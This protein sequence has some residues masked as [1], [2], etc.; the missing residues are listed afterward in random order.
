MKKITLVAINARF[1][2]SSLA[3]LCL[4]HAAFNPKA[5]RLCEYNINNSVSEIAADIISRAP[6][7]A[8]FSCYIWNI[9]HVIK[10]A[11]I[12]KK[13]LPECLILLGGPEV[14]FDCAAFMENCTF[15][16]IIIRGAGELPFAH[17]TK[18]LAQGKDIDT[19]PSAR[20]RTPQ[21]IIETNDAPPYDLSGQPFLYEDLS[22]FENK[23]IYYETSRGCPFCCAYCMSAGDTL[24]FLPLKRVR[25]DLEHFMRANVRQVK[26][27]DRTFNHPDERAREIFAALIALKAKYPDSTTNFHF[28]ISA[29]LLSKQTLSL[30]AA[31]PKHLIQFEVGIQSTNDATLRAVCRAHDT[32]KLLCRTA[33]LCRPQNL[34]VYVDLIA[35]LPMETMQ[36][37]A[38][39]FNDAYSVGSDKIQL[40]FLKLLKGSRMRENATTYGIVYSDHAPYEVLKTHT[41]TYHELRRLHRIEHVLDMLYNQ[42]QARKT[43]DFLI[44]NF[45]SPFVF[46][47]SFTRH[48][49]AAGYFTRPQKMQ[50]LFEQLFSFAKSLTNI[51]TLRETLCFDWLCLQKPGPWPKGIQMEAENLREYFADKQMTKNFFQQQLSIRELERRCMLVTFTHLF[52]APSLL[53]FDYSFSHNDEN[54]ITQVK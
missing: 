48:L 50:A 7:A 36:S 2:H 20:I 47:E 42:R 8:G 14:S 16:D 33:A 52:D 45:N 53:L 43:L 32:Q 31:A 17:L 28:E 5:I 27:V 4:K 18:C 19:T 29:S 25:L 22:A 10:V 12:V 3:L 40:G 6:D 37:F 38:H 51:D 11:S 21:G 23:M 44:P 54:F 35:G 1:S 46:F 9:E 41:M 13:V 39:S 24:S 26:L 34:R 49:E 15:S 30:L